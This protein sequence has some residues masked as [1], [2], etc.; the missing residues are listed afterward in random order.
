MQRRTKSGIE[1]L[2]RTTHKKA[3]QGFQKQ[4]FHVCFTEEKLSLVHSAAEPG[5]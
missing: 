4:R 3:G 1:I 2:V 5:S